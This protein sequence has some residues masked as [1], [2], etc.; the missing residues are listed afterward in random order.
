MPDLT[1]EIFFHCGSAEHFSTKVEGSKGKFHT[2]TYGPMPRGPYEYDY[3]CTC[4]S[5][6][7][8]KGKPCK[9]IEQVKKTDLHCKWMQFTDGDKPIEKNGEYFC[10]KCGEHAHAQ[11][12]GV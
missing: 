10:P 6:K 9:H 11:R 4:D 12:Y 1:I 5:F 3:S 7:Y 2:V 8:G